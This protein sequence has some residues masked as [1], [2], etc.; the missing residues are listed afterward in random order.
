MINTMHT[1]NYAPS[2]TYGSYILKCDSNLTQNSILAIVKRGILPGLI[3][4]MIKFNNRR[5]RK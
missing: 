2:N 5:Q 3:L 1:L 4:I